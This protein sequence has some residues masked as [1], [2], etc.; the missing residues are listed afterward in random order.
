[1]VTPFRMFPGYWSEKKQKLN[2]GTESSTPKNIAESS[3]T[4]ELIQQE[5]FPN[6]TGIPSKQW[7]QEIIDKFHYKEAPKH[8]TLTAYIVAEAKSG[9]RL[10]TE[11]KKYTYGTC[12]VLTGF[13]QSFERSVRRKRQYDFNDINQDFYNDFVQFL[14]PELWQMLVAGSQTLKR[15]RR[16]A[17]DDGLHNNLTTNTRAFKVI[18]SEVDSIYLTADDIVILQN[19]TCQKTRFGILPGTCF[20]LAVILLRGIPITVRSI[21]QTSRKSAEQSTLS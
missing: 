15:L 13:M 7:L 17:M 18:K 19:L 21:N 11:S 16:V 6:S 10:T 4:N 3:G 14:Q 5:Y 2:F 12:R 9:K 8:E 20:S 1:M